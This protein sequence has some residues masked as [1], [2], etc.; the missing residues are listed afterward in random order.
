MADKD[1]R[2]KYYLEGASSCDEGNGIHYHKDLTDIWTALRVQSVG[3]LHPLP[4][5]HRNA[6]SV[7]KN[8]REGNYCWKSGVDRYRSPESGRMTTIVFPA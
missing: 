8:Y 5:S 7:Q 4:G 2:D 6:G 3:T 1:D